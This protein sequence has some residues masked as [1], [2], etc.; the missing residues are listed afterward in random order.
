MS[1]RIARRLLNAFI[2]AMMLSPVAAWAD[3]PFPV[4]VYNNDGVTTY[5]PLTDQFLITA[6]PLAIR[7][8]PNLPPTPIAAPATLTIAIF[9]DDTG[10]LSGG[11]TGPDV[12]VTSGASTLLQGEVTGFTSKDSFGLRFYYPI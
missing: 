5:D 6:T 3:V 9:V 10:A 2:C 1:P 4:I 11:V 8:A 7:T 12:V